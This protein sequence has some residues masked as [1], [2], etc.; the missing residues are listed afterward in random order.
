MKT[1]NSNC[2]IAFFF[3][4]F[5]IFPSGCPLVIFF[6]AKFRREYKRAMLCRQPRRRTYISTAS[7]H[8]VGV[9]QLQAAHDHD[10]ADHTTFTGRSHNGRQSASG[11]YGQNSK[12]PRQHAGIPQQQP[13]RLELQPLQEWHQ[14]TDGIT[15]ADPW[16]LGRGCERCF[17]LWEGEEKGP[18]EALC[19]RQEELFENM[20]FWGEIIFRETCRRKT[21]GWHVLLRI[22]SCMCWSVSADQFPT[23]E[24]LLAVVPGGVC[25]LDF[26]TDVRRHTW[27]KHAFNQSNAFPI[28][29]HLT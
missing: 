15:V 21:D 25:I 26:E 22:F 7:G 27:V 11:H 5:N 8:Y 28:N 16:K 10:Q 18:S 6:S 24:C 29:A 20:N 3:H 12:Y 9:R 4:C 17:Y 19:R 23:T 2:R 14:P 13:Q 1:T